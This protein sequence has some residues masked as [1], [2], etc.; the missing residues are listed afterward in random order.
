MRAFLQ[1]LTA[2]PAQILETLQPS[3]YTVSYTVSTRLVPQTIFARIASHVG[4]LLR[5]ILGLSAALLL[6][7]KSRFQVTR[8]EHILLAVLSR[9]RTHQLLQ[10]ADKCQWMYLAPCVLVVFILVFRRNYTGTSTPS[11]IVV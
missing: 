11:G 9:S 3:P 10:F 1:R 5:I 8:T 6:W 2:P 4:L 7:L